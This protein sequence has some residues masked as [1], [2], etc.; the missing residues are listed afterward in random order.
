MRF[1]E[2]NF[3]NLAGPVLSIIRVALPHSFDDWSEAEPQGAAARMFEY[4]EYLCL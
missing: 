4:V 2:L 1:F 3:A